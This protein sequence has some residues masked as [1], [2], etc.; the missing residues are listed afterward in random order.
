MPGV[1]EQGPQRLQESL[2][3][4]FIQREVAPGQHASAGHVRAHVHRVRAQPAAAGRI[5][6][7][8]LPGS[9]RH[10]PARGPQLEVAQQL[11]TFAGLASGS[12]SARPSSF[13]TLA[14]DRLAG[15][16]AALRQQQRG[17]FSRRSA[18]R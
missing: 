13:R 14:E 9:S 5:A 7:F 6:E 8:Q 17:H 1:A 15:K 4:G 10:R 18:R 11:R 2:G 3:L 16:A 12:A